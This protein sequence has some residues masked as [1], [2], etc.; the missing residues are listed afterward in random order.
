MWSDEVRRKLL[1]PGQRL[2]WDTR[3]LL[4]GSFADQVGALRSAV[5]VGLLSQNEARER[6]GLNAVEGGDELLRPA[7]TLSEADDASDAEELDA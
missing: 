3:D 5:E 4:K 2:V 6:L 1:S 7:N